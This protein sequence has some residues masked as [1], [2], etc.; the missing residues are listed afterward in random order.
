[1]VTK[2]GSDGSIGVTAKSDASTK[3]AP[4]K[5]PVS[6]RLSSVRTFVL[7]GIET[8]LQ[9][10]L[11]KAGFEVAPFDAENLRSK[12]GPSANRKGEP[13]RPIAIVW[14]APEMDC[15]TA[16]LH[17]VDPAGFLDQ[18]RDEVE[19]LLAIFKRH[20][21]SLILVEAA[22]LIDPDATE[23]HKAIRK[24]LQLPSLKL[25]LVLAEGKTPKAGAEVAARPEAED[26]FS[27]LSRMIL[28]HDPILPSLLDEL[29]AASVSTL[30]A[31]R[32]T[33]GPV[34]DVMAA[35]AGWRA[36]L[37][38]VDE[39]E[40]KVEV[41]QTRAQTL[42]TMLE[43]HRQ[44]ITSLK[45]ER[46]LLRKQVELQ[47]EAMSAQAAQSKDTPSP[48]SQQLVRRIEAQEREVAA[49]RQESAL[50][51]KQLAAAKEAEAAAHAANAA[52]PWTSVDLIEKV[53]LG[54]GT[55][56]GHGIIL[57]SAESVQTHAVFGPYLRLPHGTYEACIALRL[58]PR[59]L[60]RPVAVLELAWNVDDILGLRRIEGAR[61][62]DQ[63]FVLREAFA[64]SPEQAKTEGQGLEVRLW[65]DQIAAGEVSVLCIRKL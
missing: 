41:Q 60:G 42:N 59:G 38:R 14:A 23:A 13:A 39:L 62:Q 7:Q 31:K 15:G 33:A 58:K 11:A 53:S 18:W 55:T 21:R 48:E 28:H 63:S 22:C 56:R 51:S 6:Q 47:L 43:A 32:P 9:N 2:S 29:E 24:R 30:A 36:R 37:R 19:K 65:T 61:L 5:G 17:G 45:I 4:K 27:N 64:I 52:L 35:L 49:A 44:E 54:Q 10:V 12:L 46:D 34:S 8:P 26:L 1:M 16:L 50:L 3:I 20:R 57:L 40:E 25:P